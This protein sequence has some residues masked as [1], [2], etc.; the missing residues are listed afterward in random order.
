MSIARAREEK[1]E[2]FGRDYNMDLPLSI[3]Y[4][5]AKR[6]GFKP[7]KR[8]AKEGENNGKGKTRENDK[9]YRLGLRAHFPKF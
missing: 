9:A 2:Y 4:N 8:R 6:G 5:S 7:P 3:C 1:R